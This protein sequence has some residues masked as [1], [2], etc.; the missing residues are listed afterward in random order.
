MNSCILMAT[1]IGV[2]EMRYTQENQTPNCQFLVEFQG[3]KDG[4]PPSKLKCI[5]WSNLATEA[6]ESCSVGDRLILEGRLTM[7]TVDRPE[8]F[9]EKVAEFNL[10]RIH[11][12]GASSPVAKKQAPA[13]PPET[14]ADQEWD[15]VAALDDQEWPIPKKAEVAS[16]RPV[17]KAQPKSVP[18]ED[19]FEDEGDEG[20]NLDEI[21][22]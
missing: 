1:V 17:K 14:V 13:S 4:D 21:P 2:P 18:V 16:S 22:F 5:A 12:L 9:K 10:S 3:G 6:Q 8:G 11:P 7:K 19:D 15:E 20:I